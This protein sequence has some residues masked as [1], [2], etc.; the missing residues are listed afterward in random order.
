MGVSQGSILGATLFPLYVNDL[1]DVVIC[2]IAIF[3]DDTTIYSKY[4]Q[5]SHLWQQLELAFE[6]ESNLRDT[7]DSSRRWLVNFRAGKTQFVLFDWSSSSGAID[8]KMDGSVRKEKSY[9]KIL[10]LSFSSKLNWGSYIVSIAKTAAM[11]I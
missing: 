6:F 9:F 2:K 8:V 3:A 4:E 10:G 1:P 11:K 5:A 7:V